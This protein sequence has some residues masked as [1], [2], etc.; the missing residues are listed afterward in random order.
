MI[1]TA[2]RVKPSS[3]STGNVTI[4]VN[5]SDNTVRALKED[6]TEWILSEIGFRSYNAI[7]NGGFDFAQRQTPGNLTTYSNTSGRAYGA[8]RFGMTNQN[9]SIQYQRVD[10][11]SSTEVG[12]TSRFYGKFKKITSAGKMVISQ[13]IEGS[14]CMKYRGRKVRLQCKMKYSVASAM[15][16]RLGLLELQNA[17][18]IDTIPATFISAFGANGTDPT[19]GT[20]LAKIAPL[21]AIGGDIVNNAVDCVLTNGWVLYSATFL[22]PDNS[23]NL[24]P[25]IWTDAQPAANDE[26]HITEVGLYDGEDVRYWQ[27]E[28]FTTELIKCQ[29]YYQKTFNLDIGP[30]QNL[31]LNTGEFKSFATIAGAAVCNMFFT[32]PVRMRTASQTVTFFNPSAANAQ[33]RDI[34]GSFDCS[35]TAVGTNAEYGRPIACTGHASTAQLNV[36]ACHMTFDAEL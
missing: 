9:A 23:K 12:I 26:L 30:Q 1:T 11:S 16:V 2:K 7:M 22:V 36:L 35:A 34:T 19:F 31:G 13:V 14:N 20:N 3:P 5:S 29:R 10:T 6:G 15:T 17:G 18:T 33:F 24:I 25:C 21:T 27:P 4:Y 28:N 8:D 32:L